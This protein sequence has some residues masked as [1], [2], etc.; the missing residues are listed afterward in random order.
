MAQGKGWKAEDINKIPPTKDTFMA[1]WKSIR[2]YL[3]I[4][5]FGI[6]GVVV[7]KG[8]W[9]T[10]EHNEMGDKPQ[11]EFFYIAEGRATFILDGEEFD[12]PKGTCL[13]VEP[14]VVRSA[15][16]AESSTTVLIV[17]AP[18]GYA[19]EAPGWDK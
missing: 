9:V 10:K 5:A 7:N 3:G 16:A 4:E 17:G 19:Y 8:D 14:E 13:V 15:V 11:Q 12:A 18:V 1:G 2:N 6:N